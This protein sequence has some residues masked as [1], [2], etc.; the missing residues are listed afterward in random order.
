MFLVDGRFPEMSAVGEVR[1]HST[2]HDQLVV[3]GHLACL[4]PLGKDPR[5]QRRQVEE[6]ASMRT[7]AG[8]AGGIL[9]RGYDPPR[10]QVVP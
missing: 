9:P 5:I 1:P 8:Q 2:N 3:A 6:P 4:G 10:S 7:D